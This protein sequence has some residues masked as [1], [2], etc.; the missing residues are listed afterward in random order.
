MSLRNAP[1]PSIK[2]RAGVLAAAL[3]LAC[4]HA[5]SAHAENLM[6][7]YRQALTSDP[8]LQQAEAQ[9]RI[10]EAGAAQ[11]RA[12][13]LPQINGSVNFQDSHGSSGQTLLTQT[14]TGQQYFSTTG[15]SQGRTRTEAVGLDQV[16]FD[17]G[18]FEQWRSGKASARASESQYV[19]AQQD[20]ILRVAQAYFTVLTDED[21]LKFAE[22]NEKA[23]KK[24][25]DQAQ[26]KYDVGFAAITDVVDA[27]A[28]HDT[29]VA[30]V[31]A[32]KNAVF[33]DRQ[34][35][36]QITGQKPGTLEA[37]TDQLPMQPPQPDDMED[38]VKTA[39]ASN[40]SLE[41]QRELVESAQHGLSAARAGR[42]PTLGA[43]VSYSRRPSWGPGATGDLAG[44]PPNVQQVLRADSRSNDTTVGLLLSVPLFA[45]GGI[46]ARIKQ[47]IAQRDQA[48]DVLEQD[49]RSV[50]SNT[51]NAFNA[52]KAGISS[53]EAQKQAVISSK[54]ALD[55]TQA[56]Y[57]IGTRTIVDLLIAQQNYFL[58][59]SNY[60]QAR[61]AL[62]IN[63]LNLKFAA[64]TLSV[65]DLETV[66]ALLQ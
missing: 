59:Q 16:L 61:H 24:Q 60:S 28:Q 14:T 65:K 30:Q 8:L 19:A 63:Q 35:L 48:Q 41:A 38:W 27:K 31:I 34:A 44:L 18:K 4:G 64:G 37:L 6:D 46:H 57:Q 56:G 22:A 29:A 5:A 43:S 10:G 9:S 55:A 17:L 58:A 62:V 32:A 7:A 53:V 42:L 50:V 13:L 49:R 47:N 36:A 26:A 52:I 2:F 39:L 51:R 15:H 45:G 12:L 1:R 21:N 3:A 23:L 33:N 20:L 11:S 54:T 40:P 66:N 25:L